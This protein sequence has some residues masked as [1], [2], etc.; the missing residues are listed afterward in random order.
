LTKVETGRAAICVVLLF[1][2]AVAAAQAQFDVVIR[3]GRI[4]DGTGN[5]W[6]VA[7]IAIRGETIVGIAKHIDSSGARVIDARGLTVAPGFIDVHSHSEDANQGIVRVPT[8]E[9]NV[10]QGV[11]TVFA[12]PDGFGEVPIGPFLERVAAARPMINV[13]AFIGHGSVRAK[14]VGLDNR[15][16]TASELEQMR[17][18]VRIGMQEGA[19]GLSTGLFYTPAS[20]APLEEVIELAKVAAQYGGI[21][22]SHMRDEGA[23]IVS[24]VRDTI[25]IGELGGLPT[26]VTHHKVMGKSNWGA[27]VQTLQLIDTA[28]ARGVDVTIDQYPYTASSTQL[29][30]GLVPQWARD[31]G[32]PRL[33]ERLRDPATAARIK[34]DIAAALESGRGGGNPDN[35]VITSCN[36]SPEFAGKSLGQILRDHQRE[37]TIA[38]A[39][40]LVVEIVNLGACGAV[41]HAI[42]EEDL[43]RIMR[44]PATM[45]ASDAS[46]GEPIFGRDV[47]HPRAYGAFARVLGVYVRERN[48][49]T[50]EEAVRKMSSFPAQR[51][52]LADRG[53]LRAGMKADIA[54]FDAARVR[55]MATFEKPHQYAQGML[56]VF[57]NG[58]LV[59][60][61][62][63]TTTARP[64]RVLYGAGAALQPELQPQP[65][66]SSF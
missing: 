65:Q 66:R 26:Q 24:S 63:N 50:L 1:T 14:V 39:T 3:G 37:P 22:Q 27:S 57:V 20:Y 10:R 60:D 51:M 59:L 31:G 58:S 17:N 15:V 33:L 8:A 56:Y 9:N 4:V 44:H 29:E 38:A 16:A 53:L 21:H 45:I 11:T 42:A 18:L 36:W 2:C 54:I 6:R 30:A 7:D 46:P 12:N 52:G 40:D 34:S 64:G 28:R 5:P 49:L 55:D 25:A 23:E 19:F 41:F 13:G 32:R 61:K 47:P 35:V 43:V 62:G 48:V